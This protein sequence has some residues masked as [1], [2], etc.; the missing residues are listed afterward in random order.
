MKVKVYGSVHC[1]TCLKAK[2]W[3]EHNQLPYQFIDLE[4]QRINHDR[5]RRVM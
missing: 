1:V 5:S 2:H 3:L 4:Q